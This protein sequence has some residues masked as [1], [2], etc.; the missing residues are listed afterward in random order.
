MCD[1]SLCPAVFVSA[2]LRSGTGQSVVNGRWAVDPPGEYQAGGTTFLYS[3]PKAGPHEHGEERG[4]TLTAPGPTTTQLQLYVSALTCVHAV[5]YSNVERGR[6]VWLVCD[7]AQ[8]LIWEVL[9]QEW[10][11]GMSH[12]FVKT[13]LLCLLMMIL[14]EHNTSELMLGALLF[15]SK[16]SYHETGFFLLTVV[17]IPTFH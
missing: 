12:R 15:S 8:T 1:H 16:G 11:E 13:C 3:R 4:E 2:A 10:M 17:L 7:G 9:L 14:N 6:Q 5:Y